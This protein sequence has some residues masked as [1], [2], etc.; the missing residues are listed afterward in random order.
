MNHL[1]NCEPEVSQPPV[2]IGLVGAGN[3]AQTYIQAF[4]QCAEARIV[5]VAD[6][7][8]EA[9]QAMAE[10]LKCGAYDSHKAM[11]ENCE[12]DAVI[13][14]TPPQTHFEVSMYFIERKVHVLCEK[15]LSVDIESSVRMLDFARQ[16]HVKLT[17]ASKFRYVDDVI[18]ARSIVASGILGEIILFENV[19]ASHVDMSAR[20]NSVPAI[21]GGGVLIDNGTHSVDV[22]RYFLGPLAEVD[23]IEGKRSQGLAVEETVRVFV[24]SL[25]GV[26]GNIDLSW[27][28]NKERDSYIDIYGSRGTISV[29][30]KQSKFR[31]SSS[32][33]WVV[34]GNGYDKI[35][36]F[37][38]QIE[39]FARA[40]RGEERLLITPEDALASVMVVSAAY[41]ALRQHRWTSVCYDLPK[42]TSGQL[43]SETIG[44][45][46]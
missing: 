37:R 28:I 12:L 16:K 46:A 45:A 44:A 19:F 29:G 6:S 40:I 30:W 3:I 11:A 26:V 22:T 4:A 35:Q 21:S 23:V 36:A 20:W 39:N 15:P 8:F 13:V 33:D 25:D 5:A 43:Y 2:K 10:G 27:S 42:L 7:R 17:M 18:R 31:Q 9:A 1:P 41:N 34:F 24:R 14:C 38:S 32:R